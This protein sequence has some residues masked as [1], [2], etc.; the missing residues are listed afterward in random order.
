MLEIY[1][2][3]LCP[4]SRKLRIVL[5]EKNIDFELFVEQYWQRREGFLKMNPRGDT[6][7]L[8][9]ED[10]GIIY[11][12]VALFEFLEEAYPHY[13]LLGEDIAARFRVR[14]IN[15][16][17]DD[18]FYY[19]VTRY[20]IT[21]KVVKPTQGFG[22]PNSDFI[23]AAKRNFSYHMQ[24]LHHLIARSPYLAGD[25]LTLADISAAAQISVLDFMNDIAWEKYPEV[26][27]WYALVK[28]RPS[29]RSILHDVAAGIVPPSHYSNLDF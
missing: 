27:E 10:G 2:Y 22:A 20:I 3:P 5:R 15:E 28:S 11:G 23:R 18:K 6:P 4:F 21:E 19:E 9:T 16:W 29:F 14:K 12:R 8:K 25:R 7:V 13:N 26:K 17:F 1:H 24:Y